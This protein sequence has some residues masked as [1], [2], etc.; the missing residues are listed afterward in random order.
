MEEFNFQLQQL[1]GFLQ[2]ELN[3]HV[4]PTHGISPA[5]VVAR[6]RAM[7]DYL[8]ATKRAGLDPAHVEN[9]QFMWGNVQSSKADVENMMH[10]RTLPGHGA[11]DFYSMT[12]NANFFLQCIR[13]LT[14]FRD[15]MAGLQPRLEEQERQQARMRAEEEARQL[16][17]RQAE[18]AAR[19]LALRQAEEA[20]RQLAQRQA[21][22]AQAARQRAKEAALQLAQRQIEEAAQALAQRQV[23]E[24][25]LQAARAVLEQSTAN[26]APLLAETG[27]ISERQPEDEPGDGSFIQMISGPRMTREIEKAVIDLQKDIDRA[28]VAFSRVLNA[29]GFLAGSESLSAVRYL[30]A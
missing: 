25:A 8:I 28:I 14:Q 22:E 27:A 13:F 5:Q 29:H 6:Y 11:T 3:A 21:E 30:G 12:V 1:P 2:N 19:Q 4:G 7:A 23:E 26:T 17:R 15:A 9:V 20:A 10:L 24:Q 16:A 18:E